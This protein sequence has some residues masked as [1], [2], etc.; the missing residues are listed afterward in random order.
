MRIYLRYLRSLLRHKWFVFLAGYHYT[1]A[2]W[3]RLLKHDW[4]KFLPSEFIPYA[5]HFYGAGD[6]RLAY[7]RAWLRHQH[8]NDH[9]W[10]HHALIDVTDGRDSSEALPMSEAQIREMVA[11]W[12][13]ACRA[14]S[15]HWPFDRGEWP[16]LVENW[17]AIRLHPETR[18]MTMAVL[19]VS[20]FWRAWSGDRSLSQERWEK[21]L[22]RIEADWIC[23][24]A[25]KVSLRE[26]RIA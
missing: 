16:W 10:E 22:E 8:R 14:Y 12:F 17:S 15:G 13:G 24:E 26:H 7:L 4:S 21:M 18:S 3:W 6:H 11:D 2:S 20:P 25:L 5:R 19:R 1:V 23:R 9:H